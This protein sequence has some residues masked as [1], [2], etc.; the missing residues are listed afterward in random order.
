MI[1]PQVSRENLFIG[2]GSFRGRDYEY[3]HGAVGGWV[4]GG[5]GF[6]FLVFIIFGV[7]AFVHKGHD[8]TSEVVREGSRL[9]G[10]ELLQAAFARGEANVRQAN[11][12][13][14]VERIAEG[15]VALAG[16]VRTVATALAGEI[17]DGI[18]QNRATIIESAQG[19]VE[20][21]R[22]FGF[23]T[24]D[25]VHPDPCRDRCGARGEREFARL[26]GTFALP[27]ATAPGTIDGTIDGRVV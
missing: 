4:A 17:R 9:Q 21:G 23:R 24:F 19:I 20:A 18:H 2:D 11:T 15:Q 27:T 25:L 10:P 7:A 26:R 8:H 13:A 14:L 12:M 6:L 16:E 1:A 22:T 5:I 3:G